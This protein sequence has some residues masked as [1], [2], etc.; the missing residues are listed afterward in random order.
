MSITAPCSNT[1]PE[2]LEAVFSNTPPPYALIR[3]H[4]RHNGGQLTDF[5]IGTAAV[6]NTLADLEPTTASWR[7]PY[8]EHGVLALLPFRQIRER[9]YDYVDDGAD[10]IALSITKSALISSDELIRRLPQEHIELSGEWYD[11]DDNTYSERAR[12][13]IQDEIGGGAGANFVLKRSCLANIAGFDNLKALTLFRRLMLHETGAYW[14]FIVH[15]GDRVFVGASPERH[16]SL[17]RGIA[18]MNPISGTYRY[19]PSGPTLDGLISFLADRKETNE[20]YMV[21]DEELKMM[22]RICAT[23]GTI[24]GPTIKF[25]SRLAHT[26]YHIKGECTLRPSEILKETLLAPTV[27]GSPLESACRIIKKYEPDGRLYY[28]GIIAL[29]GRD[30]DGNHELDSSILIRTADISST[31]NLRVSVGATLVRDSDPLSEAAETKAK[32]SGLLLAL[33]TSG[34]DQG[35][36]PNPRNGIAVTFKELG[37]DA[38]VCSA[39]AGRNTNLSRFWLE[40]WRHRIRP[41]KGLLALSVLIV[42]AEDTF[43]SMIRHQ[44][45][46]LG[47]SAV[48]RRHDEPFDLN[49]FDVIV[50]GPGPGNPLDASDNKI[51]ALERVIDTVLSEQR[52]FIAVCLSHQVLSRKLGLDLSRRHRPNQGRQCQI[53]LFGKQEFVGF[54]NSFSA[55]SSVSNITSK[56]GYNVDICRDIETNEVFALRSEFFVSFQFHTESVLSRAGDQILS[57]YLQDVVR[58]RSYLRTAHPRL[59]LAVEP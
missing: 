34:A 10:L 14:T 41:Q 45:E 48:V 30:S 39:L 18:T 6:L 2:M 51:A 19:P 57:H 28:S 58:A 40:D 20:L 26:E 24:Y 49:L 1:P 43:T 27:T 32:A 31:G 11:L 38:R 13:I 53:S 47:L 16:V 44:L 21:V 42:D 52:P 8:P 36:L 35:E 29:I 50:M 17:S 12:T 33:K 4:S 54:Y 15:T 7:S 55:T 25:M 46:S 3:R 5:L 23:G 59:D 9:G 56:D 22:A 37:Q